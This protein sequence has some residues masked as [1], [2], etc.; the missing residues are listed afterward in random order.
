MLLV[1]FVLFGSMLVILCS[2]S[3]AAQLGLTSPNWWAICLS[4]LYGEVAAR[5]TKLYRRHLG[6][7]LMQKLE[8]VPLLRIP[9]WHY[10]KISAP[11][12]SKAVGL[13]LMILLQASN[14]IIEEI[15]FRGFLYN[16]TAFFGSFNWI[17]NGGLFVLYH[18]FQASKTYSLFPLGFFIAGY[19]AIS[20][21][22]YGCMIVHYFLNSRISIQSSVQA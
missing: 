16:Q 18:F 3:D 22:I 20:G 6:Q 21:D 7:K 13:M 5:F 12:Y 11:E 14:V 8:T 9:E 4:P 19:Y 10:Q 15:Y 2:S 17:F 1:L